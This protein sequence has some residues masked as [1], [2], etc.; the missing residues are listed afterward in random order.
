MSRQYKD[1]GIEWIGQIPS[2]W[3][4]VPTKRNFQYKKNIVGTKSDVYD[5]LALTMGGVIKRNKD[6]NEGLQP[7]KFDG[8]Q[9]LKPNELVFKLIDLANAKTSRVGLSKYTGIVSPAYIILRNKQKDNRFYYYWFMFMYYNLIFNHMGD[10]GVRSAL[11]PEDVLNIPIPLISLNDQLPIAD[12][13]DKKCA[14]IDGL[15]ELQEQMIAQLTDYKQSVI[16][17][18]VTKG[19]NP[20]VEFVPSGVDWIGEIPKGW[21]V[22]RM[23]FLGTFQNGLTYTPYDVCGAEG[24]LVLRSSNI[25]DSKLTFDDNVFVTK[26][27]E[28]LMVKKGD[29]IICSRN[30]S[31]S[32]VGKCALVEENI[33]KCSFGAFMVRFRSVIFQKYAYYLVSTV[34]P[35]YK[36]LFTTTTINQL[37][38]GMLSSMMGVLPPKVEQQTIATYLDKKCGEID[39]LIRMKQK[40]IET[41]KEYKKSMIYEAVTGKINVA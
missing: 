41:L 5:R 11:S 1:S 15:I 34:I 32:L 8:Y 31:A 35:Q 14:E 18:A 25:Q 21:K 39:D 19:L 29:I 6:D 23:K 4:I 7:E 27:P 22:M 40:K 13:L 16:T 12:F 26:A 17:E 9:I 30:G 33:K 20:N 38:K 3:T 10:D 36:Q 37:T 28:E 2:D 24:I